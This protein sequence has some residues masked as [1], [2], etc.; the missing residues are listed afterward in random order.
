MPPIATRPATGFSESCMALTEPFEVC[1]VSV[2]HSADAVGTEA[3]LLAFHVRP[4]CRQPGHGGI[5][6][7]LRPHRRA[8]EGQRE[9]AHHAERQPGQFRPPGEAADHE[10]DRD[11]DQQD[12]DHLEQ[13]AQRRR[14]LQRHGAVRAVPA[15][16]IGAELLDRDHRRHR[17]RPESPVRFI[18]PLAST[19]VAVFAPSNVLGTPCQVS[20]SD[21]ASISGRNTRSTPR[22]VST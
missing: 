5:R 8:D 6:L 12:R 19:S 13:V 11:R 1:V 3:L 2:D 21:Q 10:H 16:A 7:R 20:S 22:V 15:A 14:V 18:S 17:A 4:A 9:R